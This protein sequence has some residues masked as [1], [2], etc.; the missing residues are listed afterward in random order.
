MN[1][2][3]PS[4]LTQIAEHLFG[5]TGFFI[6]YQDQEHVSIEFIP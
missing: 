1:P 4:D 2:L 3:S 6:S 5:M